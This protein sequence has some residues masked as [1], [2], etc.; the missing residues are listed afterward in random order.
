[1]LSIAKLLKATSVKQV[2]DFL[3]EFESKQCVEWLPV[4]GRDNNL[5]IINLGS[6]PAAGVIERVT[7]A[8][9]AVIDLEWEKRGQPAHPKSP[10][11][12]IEQWWKFKGGR[13]TN[14][15][16]LRDEA[17][18][19]LSK[20]VQVTIRDSER[21]DRPTIDVRDYGTG[22][23]SKDFA[24]TILSLNESRKLNKLFLAG[25]FGQ[26]G[27]TALAY[28][29]FT[30]IFSRATQ[31]NGNPNLVGA[32]IAR[33]NQGNLKVD[34]HGIYEYMVDR[35][36]GHPF[37]LEIPETLFPVGTL[38]RHIS[39]DLGKY[40]AV[41]TAPTGSLW[42]LTHNYLFD[43][44]LPFRIGDA[45]ENKGTTRTVAGNHRRLT[46][47]K[48]TEYQRDATMT[49]R[50]GSVTIKWW[51]LSAEGEGAR[52]RITNY[53]MISKPIVVTYN[54]QKHGDFP[55]SVIKNDLKW[56]YLDRYLIVH[57]D[58]DKLDAESRRQLFSTT[59]ESIRATSLGSEL[60][61]LVTDT[62]NGDDELNRLDKERKKSY[63]CKVDTAPVEKIRRR[64]AKRIKAITTGGTG[65]NSPRLPP[66]DSDKPRP[67]KP[68]IRVQVPPTFLEITSPSP[69]KIYASRRFTI[70]FQTDADP[71]YFMCPDSFIAVLA[72]PLIGNYSGTT[73][74]REG[75]GTAYFQAAEN[76]EIG[77]K[78]KIKFEIRPNESVPLKA[79]VEVE[80][81]PLP[82]S[83]GS[84]T[85]KTPTPNVNPQWVNEGDEFWKD[86]N[87]TKNSVAEVREEKDSVDIFVS[88]G[89]ARLNTL[90]SRTQRRNVSA[91]N[92]LKNF[93]LEHISYYAYFAFA[94]RPE[95]VATQSD[96]SEDETTHQ[97]ELCHAC[98]TI[99]GIMDDLFNFLV[100]RTSESS[101]E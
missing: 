19:E 98:D 76:L 81:V 21:P 18:V 25:A 23:L 85:G 28:S 4:G 22:L 87:W 61:R 5:P 46:M 89:N 58:C 35:S 77:T 33:F 72:T 30:V 27:S 20:K 16:D 12:A 91:V 101:D 64:L 78:A 59:R 14:I 52:N 3:V 15:E 65:G 100:E 56:P 31:H 66:P 10:R 44:V 49:F 97:H 17:I 82:E 69:R 36:T 88:A 84:A 62:L 47:G 57:V 1:M 95:S 34:K 9:D 71:M 6:D 83:V 99:C 63:I 86:N 54:G 43:T 79:S 29:C 13:T 73:N 38:V 39:M 11:D 48:Y 50:S 96:G 70:C 40:K 55:N 75:Y 60:R 32:T 45:R 92:S 37:A 90:I 67:T 68:P 2:T 42:W 93:Y 7:N 8:I 24:G 41:M 51:V 94:D 53:S 80:V 74:V 26:G